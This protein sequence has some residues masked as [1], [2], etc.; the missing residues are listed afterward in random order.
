[1]NKAQ[2]LYDRSISVFDFS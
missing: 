1:M 2:R